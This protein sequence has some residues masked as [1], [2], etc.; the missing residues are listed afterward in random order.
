M[1]FIKRNIMLFLRSSYITATVILCL[2]IGIYGSFKAYENIRRIGFGEYR[3]AIEYSDGT[4]KIFDLCLE[5]N[6]G[7][8]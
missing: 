5:I 2:F 8:Q 6:R 3:S 7:K 1:I 4:L